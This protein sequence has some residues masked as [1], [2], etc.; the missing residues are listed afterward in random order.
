M[1]IV[2]TIF[3]YLSIFFA[4]I[5]QIP[6]I[7]TVIK[8]R[9]AK[10]ISYPYIGLILLDCLFYIIYGSGFLLDNDLNGIPVI[11]A[12]VIPFLLTTILLILKIF[13]SFRKKK[14][15]IKRNKKELN[16]HI[17]ENRTEEQADSI[18]ITNNS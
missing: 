10:N 2:F 4:F 16:S 1:H 8:H 6:Q 15:R 12:G 3:G 14:L 13:F 17:D 7:I 9:S 18:T 5:V 11:L